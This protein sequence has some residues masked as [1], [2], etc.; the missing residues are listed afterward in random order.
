MAILVQTET[1][2]QDFQR[3]IIRKERKKRALGQKSGGTCSPSADASQ[4]PASL[5]MEAIS[6]FGTRLTECQPT[7]DTG[8]RICLDPARAHHAAHLSRCRRRSCARVGQNRPEVAIAHLPISPA[9]CLRTHDWRLI[10]SKAVERGR[11]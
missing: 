4:T 2:E 5:L 9:S 7:I 6:A 11:H 10:L 8:G 1:S 3:S